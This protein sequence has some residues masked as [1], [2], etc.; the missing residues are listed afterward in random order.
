MQQGRWVG[1]KISLG[2]LNWSSY[3]ATYLT[4]QLSYISSNLQPLLGLLN[5]WNKLSDTE[6]RRRVSSAVSEMESAQI[7]FYANS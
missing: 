1:N 5:E 3:G 2:C 6:K 4:Q 7:D